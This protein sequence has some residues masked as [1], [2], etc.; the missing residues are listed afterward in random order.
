MES[1]LILKVIEKLYTARPVLDFLQDMNFDNKILHQLLN[2]V[3]T[4][5]LNKRR[6]INLD[7]LD[8]DETIQFENPDQI[9]FIP[10]KISIFAEEI[11][12]KIQELI[13]GEFSLNRSYSRSIHSQF[14]L[15]D[16]WLNEEDLEKRKAEKKS[17]Y[18]QKKLMFFGGAD[19]IDEQE[20]PR[21]SDQE[22]IEVDRD[23]FTLL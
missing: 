23:R 22:Q 7:K 20:S 10:S 15:S 6:T 11:A 16:P 17:I 5:S 2:V 14:N 12:E 19:M 4:I 9:N 18:E 1:L 3:T 8:L 21:S 13:Q